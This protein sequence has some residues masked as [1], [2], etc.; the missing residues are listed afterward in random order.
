MKSIPRFL[1]A[2]TPGYEV[3]DVKEFISDGRIEVYL[4]RLADK[5]WRCFRCG[6]TM[7]GGRGKHRMR[8]GGM[9]IMG[10]KTY[11]YLWR[12]KGHCR[13]CSK[14]RSEQIEFVSPESPHLMS[15]YAWW[16]GRLC[17]IATVSRVAELVEQDELTTWRLDY[18]RMIQMLMYYR[19]PKVTRISVDEVYARKKPKFQ[20][21]SRNKRFFTVVTDLDTH[22]VIWV[23]DGR[24]KESLDSFFKLIGKAACRRIKVVAA[25]MHEDYG[26]S[27]R[28]HCKNA[29]LVWDRFHVMKRFEEAVNDTR[30]ELHERFRKKSKMKELTRGKYRFLF[31]KKA[32]KRT[33][34]EKTHIDKVLKDNEEFIKLELI[35]ERMITFFDERDEYSA[36]GVFWE[37]GDWIIEQDFGPLKRW[38]FELERKWKTLANYF[39]HRVTSALSEGINNVIKSLKRRCFGFRNMEYFKLKILQLCGYLNSRSIPTRK[40][41]T[42]T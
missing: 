4:E 38:W 15:D 18:A 34:K 37:V 20:G 27:V 29:T 26:Y 41:I 6:E 21:E 31:L 39:K 7:H 10:L 16:I 28:E 9:P 19:I 32:K 24:D 11:I 5:P 12:E 40:S 3:I 30:K 13:N 2:A 23:T 17:E 42:C 8:L 35:K 14:A 36:R 1:S 25:D 22:K 33:S